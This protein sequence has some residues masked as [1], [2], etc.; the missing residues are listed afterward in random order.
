MNFK[1][2]NHTKLCGVFS[3]DFLVEVNYIYLND[4]IEK[5]CVSG[6]MKNISCER[7]CATYHRKYGMV[8]IIINFA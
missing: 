5:K 8:C 7:R 4:Y 3:S 1:F 2:V 6:A